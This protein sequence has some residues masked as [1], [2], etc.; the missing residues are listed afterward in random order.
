MF[1]SNFDINLLNILR[2]TRQVVK[3]IYIA[4]YC[5]YIVIV[6]SVLYCYCYCKSTP[7]YYCN[8]LFPCPGNDYGRHINSNF[9]TRAVIACFVHAGSPDKCAKNLQQLRN[10][11]KILLICTTSIKNK[12]FKRVL[13]RDNEEN[14]N[15]KQ[16]AINDNKQ[17]SPLFSLNERK[18]QRVLPKWPPKNLYLL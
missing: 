3:T 12:C 4:I 2:V 5:I 8:I 10:K 15:N 9:C 13:M 1:S 18:L 14:N 16:Q 7:Q 17:H 11:C 6:I